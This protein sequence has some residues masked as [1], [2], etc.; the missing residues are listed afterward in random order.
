MKLNIFAT[1]TGF[2]LGLLAVATLGLFLVAAGSGYGGFA[3]IA[4]VTCLVAIASAV[5]VVGG[6]IHHDHK[7]NLQ[8][9]H[10]P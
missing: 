6:T 8:T 1:W 4:G 10:F 9:P 5:G 7:L 2:M 3:V